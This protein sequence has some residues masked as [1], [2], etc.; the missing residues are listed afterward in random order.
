MADGA[1]DIR[2]RLRRVVLDEEIGGALSPMQ[3]ADRNQAIADLA[4]DNRFAL[5]THPEAAT[6]LHLSVQDGR[7]VFDIRDESDATLQT[8]VLAPGPFRSMIRDY[9]MLLDSYAAAVAEGREARIQA[10]DMGRRGLHNEGAELVM[11]RLDGK[12]LLDFDTARR[13]FTLICALHRR[14]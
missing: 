8:L 13:L 5:A 6:I 14:A 12:V 9:Q 7:L 3:E 11:A 4:A 10:I 2:G 1:S